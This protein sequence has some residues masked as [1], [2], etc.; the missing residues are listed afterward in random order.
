MVKN[1]GK[2][3]W[4]KVLILSVI[5]FVLFMITIPVARTLELVLMQSYHQSCT[6]VLYKDFRRDKTE[7]PWCNFRNL[8]FFL[9]YLGFFK[10][11]HIMIGVI[12]SMIYLSAT[13]VVV[14]KLK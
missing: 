5:Y 13:T 9:P 7:D 11:D 10:G 14:K 6:V 12:V 3:G 1:K 4:Q 8:E 2:A